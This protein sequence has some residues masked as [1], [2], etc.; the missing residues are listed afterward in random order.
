MV[1]STLACALQIMS[2][3]GIMSIA[4]WL[5]GF[6]VHI[7]TYIYIY[8]NRMHE[9]GFFFAIYKKFSG[10]NVMKSFDYTSTLIPENSSRENLYSI[11]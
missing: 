10:Q 2:I 5:L 1:Y 3:A 6:P 9:V 8:A 7:R 4:A 11:L